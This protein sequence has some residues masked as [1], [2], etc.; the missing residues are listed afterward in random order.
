MYHNMPKGFLSEISLW[1]GRW[2]KVFLIWRQTEIYL[3]MNETRQTLLRIRIMFYYLFL[4]VGVH[5]NYKKNLY[6]C[7]LHQAPAKLSI[8]GFPLLWLRV[9]FMNAAFERVP[10]MF[11]KITLVF[12]V[13]TLCRVILNS[14]QP[15][16]CWTCAPWALR[17]RRIS[18][19]FIVL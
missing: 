13:C 6:K 15:S 12:F 7:K 17:S 9:I 14:N 11:F 4:L 10:F 3:S 16:V 5:F 18:L 1:P 2:V 19:S 8:R